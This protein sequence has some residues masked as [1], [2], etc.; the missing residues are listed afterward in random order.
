M[1]RVVGCEKERREKE[2]NVQHSTS[3]AQ[4]RI[5]EILNKEKETTNNEKSVKEHLWEIQKGGTQLT[6]YKI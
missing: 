3:N 6:Q 1:W 4:R 2:L 5:E